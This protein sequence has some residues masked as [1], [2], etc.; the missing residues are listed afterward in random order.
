MVK[1][2]KKRSHKH[3]YVFENY[4]LGKSGIWFFMPDNEERFLKKKRT[5]GFGM[6]RYDEGSIY[7]G[8]LLFDGKDYRKIGFGRQDFAN[9]FL[10]N[11]SLPN[12]R[13]FCY[14]GQYDYRKTDWIYG[15]G[16]LYLIDQNGKPTH[17][18]KGFYDGINKIGP[19]VGDFDS[20][21]LLEGYTPSMEI[22]YCPRDDLFYSE[23]K[24]YVPNSHLEALFIGD[25]YFEFW[26]YHQF[27]DTLFE[28]TYDKAHYLNLGLGGTKFSDWIQYIP[29]IT[30]AND[31]KRIIIHLGVNDTHSWSS[32]H[33]ILDNYKAV[34]HALKEKYPSSKLYVLTATESP[35]FESKKYK[36]ARWNAL[37]KK[38]A[39]LDQVTVIDI[40]QRLK[41]KFKKN[42]TNFF[43]EDGLH[44][45]SMG[46]IEMVEILKEIL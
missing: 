36:V 26:H 4:H 15:N 5:Y 10:G 43:S 18:I 30:I 11:I 44:L 39:S 46:Y 29:K 35:A 2:K 23:L 34:I 13:I 20:E 27:T 17:F 45:N 37:I 3:S 9:S 7:V 41:T 31:P 16:V 28:E 6:V 25:S 22:D 42:G 19:Y 33:E 32:N 38:E 40:N 24:E 21:S 12:Q 1:E 8:D 14:V